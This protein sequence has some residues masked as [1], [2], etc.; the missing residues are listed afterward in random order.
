MSVCCLAEIQAGA[1]TLNFNPDWRFLRE[2]VSGAEKAA[3]DDAGWSAAKN[4]RAFQEFGIGIGACALRRAMVEVY[5][6]RGAPA[7]VE[8]TE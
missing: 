1:E 6:R 5:S 4:Q 7:A 8:K 3:F 2:D